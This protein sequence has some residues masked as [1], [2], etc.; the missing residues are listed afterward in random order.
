[1]WTQKAADLGSNLQR[2]IEALGVADRNRIMG[3]ADQIGAM[4]D[5]AGQ[6]ALFSITQDAERLTL[7]PSGYARAIWTFLNA[8]HDFE[9]AEQVRY[10]DDQ[11]YGRIW[12]GFLCQSGCTVARDGEELKAFKE[13]I[14]GQFS[15]RNVEVE[16]CD[17][18]RA[19]LEEDDTKLV[20]AAIYR[21]GLPD[22]RIAFVDGRLDR[23]LDHPVLEAAITYESAIGVVEVV[24]KSRKVREELVR[25]F[26]EHLLKAPFDGQRL[27]VRQYSLE[28]LRRPC[29]FPTDPDDNIEAVRVNLL[30]LMP[31]DTTGERVTV[32]CMRG[33][34]RNIWQMANARFDQCDPLQEGY[35]ITQARFTIKFKPSIGMRGS[36]TLPVTISMPEGCDLKDRTD[37]ERLIGEKYL[38]RWGLLRDV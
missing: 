26:A 36:R 33:A 23:L 5:D 34:Q 18:L 16:I 35:R 10:A 9:H 14:R 27:K 30:R 12:E 29:A 2:A 6:A 31:L 24:A 4:S 32:E 15:S 13:A 37:R 20:Q 38:R 1:M 19:K 8:R 3:D 11:R 25:L 21:E 17:R 7:L 28:V 22:T